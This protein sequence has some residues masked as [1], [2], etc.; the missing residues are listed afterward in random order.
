MH[1]EE[2]D[3]HIQADIYIGTKTVIQTNTDEKK[4]IDDKTHL[5][6][7]ENDTNR[8]IYKDTNKHA[9]RYR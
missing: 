9:Q 5:H 1:T 3:I 8:Q 2:A 7:T 6:K 4:S